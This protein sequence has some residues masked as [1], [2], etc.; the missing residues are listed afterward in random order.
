MF[1]LNYIIILLNVREITFETTPTRCIIFQRF[2]ETHFVVTY[3]N[4]IAAFLPVCDYCLTVMYDTSNNN[5]GFHLTDKFMFSN[6][7]IFIVHHKFTFAHEFFS[8]SF[9]FS[10]KIF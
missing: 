8:H 4:N 7:L 9:A 5:D 6:Y 10:L 2:M 1:L 3:N